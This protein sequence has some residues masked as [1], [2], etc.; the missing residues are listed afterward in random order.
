MQQP[1]HETSVLLNLMR[2]ELSDIWSS[3]TDATSGVSTGR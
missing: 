1:E 2:L 3:S